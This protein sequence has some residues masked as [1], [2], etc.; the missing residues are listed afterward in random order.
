MTP[1]TVFQQQTY[2]K[3]SGT[4]I[5]G[6]SALNIGAA[7]DAASSLTAAQSTVSFSKSES[8]SKYKFKWLYLYDVGILCN[9]E[10]CIRQL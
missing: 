5:S 10:W 3:S 4:A 7:G 6:S 8:K 9:V 2:G 1:L